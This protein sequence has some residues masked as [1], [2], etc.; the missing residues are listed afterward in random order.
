MKIEKAASTSQA[1]NE[2]KLQML[3]DRAKR[4]VPLFMDHDTPDDAE[5]HEHYLH[6]KE[7]HEALGLYLSFWRSHETLDAA[8]IT[9]TQLA[10]IVRANPEKPG[11]YAGLL[12]L[13]CANPEH[14]S[15]KYVWRWHDIKGHIRRILATTAIKELAGRL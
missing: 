6:L 7:L 3:E 14:R 11:R 5:E 1:P 15:S 8:E 4:K 13:P 10:K 12:P 9:F 2:A